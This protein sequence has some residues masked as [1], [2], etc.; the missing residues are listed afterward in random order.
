[1]SLVAPTSQTVCHR[2]TE[3]I[4]QV[5]LYQMCCGTISTRPLN[6]NLPQSGYVSQLGVVFLRL[7]KRGEATFRTSLAT[8]TDAPTG[9]QG[10]NGYGVDSRHW[11]CE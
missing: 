1:M 6:E 10:R 2:A 3:E 9:K 11:L 5:C 4:N 8:S 7:S